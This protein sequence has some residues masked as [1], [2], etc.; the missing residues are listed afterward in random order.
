MVLSLVL[1]I[2]QKIL[3]KDLSFPE[4][5]LN[6]PIAWFLVACLF[7]VSGS[8]FLWES[9]QNFLTKTLEWFFIYFLVVAFFTT[10]KHIRIAITVLM[11]TSLTV[12]LDGLQQYY[13]TG[14]DIFSQER[15]VLFSRASASFKTANGLGGYLTIILPILFGLHCAFFRDEHKHYLS[16]ASIL[17]SVWL[18]VI[19]FSRGAWIAAVAG[20]GFFLFT[21]LRGKKN[22]KSLPVWA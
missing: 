16:L 7:S 3:T 10:K 19:T 18:L 13:L 22:F 6:K 5:P 14:M 21:T 4:T 17:I 11:I 8:V 2:V 15:G 12:V 9:F 20:I 1:W